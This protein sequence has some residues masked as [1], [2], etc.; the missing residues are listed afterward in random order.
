[1]RG[2]FS[3]RRSSAFIGGHTVLLGFFGGRLDHRIAKKTKNI[4]PPINAAE[5]G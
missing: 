1:M 5:R 4:W 3:D 2:S